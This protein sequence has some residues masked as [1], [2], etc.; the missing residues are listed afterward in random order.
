MRVLRDLIFVSNLVAYL[1]YE[2]QAE[3]RGASLTWATDRDSM[4]SFLTPKCSGSLFQTFASILFHVLCERGGLDT[5]VSRLNF[6]VPE[7]TGPLWY[8]IPLRIPDLI[9]GTLAD[10]RGGM[11]VPLRWSHRK[12]ERVVADLL[13]HE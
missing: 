3:L 6:A 10:L 13:V 2:F 8:D 11:G 7:Q 4:H 9:C 1:A 12:F 5:D